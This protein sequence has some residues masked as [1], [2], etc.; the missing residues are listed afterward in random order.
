MCVLK[1]DLN[2]GFTL[3]ELLVVVAIIGLLAS[4]VLVSLNSARAKARDAAIKEDVH[5]FTNLMTLNYNDYG[6][7]CNLIRGGWITSSATCDSAFSGTY[8]SKAR[9][10]CN[11]LY[12]NAGN[13]VEGKVLLVAQSSCNTTYAITMPLNNGKFFCSGI[14]GKG[15]YTTYN[16]STDIGCYYFP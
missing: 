1:I 5:Q 16:N 8:A 2:K 9:E 10:I 6:S 4:V 14:S 7:Y 15:E 13:Y 12:K 11:D 3:I